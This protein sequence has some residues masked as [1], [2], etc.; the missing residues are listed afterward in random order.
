MTFTKGCFNN[1]RI[2]NFD[3]PHFT[4]KNFKYPYFKII[5]KKKEI[6]RLRKSKL[7]F[8]TI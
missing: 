8:E 6:S 2:Q 4:K 7:D 1:E 3:F 5:M